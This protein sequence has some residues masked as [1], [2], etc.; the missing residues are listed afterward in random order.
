[1]NHQD[2]D[3]GDLRIDLGNLSSQKGYGGAASQSQKPEPAYDTG[4]PAPAAT[5]NKPRP[6]GIFACCSIEY[7]QPYFD[8]TTADV[9]QRILATID[10]RK[11]TFFEIIQERPDLYGP[12]WIYTTLIFTIAAAGNFS[13]YLAAFISGASGFTSKFNYVPTAAAVIYGFGVAVPIIFTFLLRMFGSKVNY[14]DTLCI[15]GYSFFILIPVLVL[16]IIPYTIAQWI[17]LMY[18][19]GSSTWFLLNNYAH[20]TEKYVGKQRYILLGFIACSQIVLL[21]V[22][23]LKFFDNIYSQ[24]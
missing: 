10:P 22:F 17:F 18:G 16:A 6:T 5:E 1:M 3:L 19:L 8:I 13:G 20:E 12:F 7:Y 23:R 11:N 9:K 21:L 2:S 24:S 14:A 4:M 15:Y